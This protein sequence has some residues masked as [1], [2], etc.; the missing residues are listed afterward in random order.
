[1]NLSKKLVLMS[2][3]AILPFQTY[4][5]W[6]P[7]WT[8]NFSLPA[9]TTIKS[10]IQEHKHAFIGLGAV[11]FGVVGY[12]AYKKYHSTENPRHDGDETPNTNHM[13]QIQI[14]PQAPAIQ[15]R[16]EPNLNNQ[17]A[18]EPIEPIINLVD[19]QKPSMPPFVCQPIHII[20]DY[21]TRIKQ[22]VDNVVHN[23]LIFSSGEDSHGNREQI[24]NHHTNGYT[25]I[26]VEPSDN[27]HENK[28]NRDPL[29]NINQRRDKGKERVREIIVAEEENSDEKNHR[30]SY[31][32]Q[33]PTFNDWNETC[34]ALKPYEL[35]TIRGHNEKNCDK[36]VSY[37]ELNKAL[38]A[39][40]ELV[41]NDRC[42]FQNPNHWVNNEMPEKLLQSLTED[43]QAVFDP[44]VQKLVVTKNSIIA[45]HGDVHG[46]VHSLNAY[47][48]DLADKGYL[49]PENPFEIINP[50]FYMI[51]LGD[52]T[53]RGWYGPE[54]IYTVLRL[55]CANP[56]KVFMVRGNHE[57]QSLNAREAIT[58]AD[59]FFAQT[60][61]KFNIK[62]PEINNKSYGDP[63]FNKI[64]KLYETLPLALYL[65]SQGANETT[66]YLLCCHG[67]IEIGFD[68]LPLLNHELGHTIA[69]TKLN[70]LNRLNALTR[71]SEDKELF[72]L[73]KNA[74]NALQDPQ[75]LKNNFNT[76]LAGGC[77]HDHKPSGIITR[78]LS[79]MASLIGFQW[80]DYESDDLK[81]TNENWFVKNTSG[82]GW[83]LSK[84]F[85]KAALITQSDD[86]SV[87]R[88]V[89]RAH[90]HSAQL[91][92]MM[93]LILNKDDRDH[94]ENSGVGKLWPPH[95]KKNA[96]H[97]LGNNCVC[98]FNVCPCTPVGLT[99]G[100][101][102]D[103]YGLLTMAKEFDDWKLHVHRIIIKQAIPQEP[104]I[105]SSDSSQ[106]EQPQNAQS[107]DVTEPQKP[108]SPR[109][110]AFTRHYQSK[111]IKKPSEPIAENNEEYEGFIL[112]I[113]KDTADGVEV[114]GLVNEFT[115]LLISE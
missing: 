3:M 16:P 72:N 113:D 48:L 81:E 46:D 63:I 57:D 17:R 75:D 8:S 77:L 90:Q 59:G 105:T 15:E 99:L 39:Y 18:E 51:F 37:D 60:S 106:N 52:Y 13:P 87:V 96:V 41:A 110:A 84:T 98:T 109:S 5:G 50:N 70:S 27:N 115:D 20:E 76:H 89:F 101:T 62:S 103:T 66:N 55:K 2:L 64:T 91:N 45:F 14:Q 67:G 44:F 85:N 111:P 1:M 71:F 26:F 22:P 88:G 35:P 10:Y 42:I 21:S 40:L 28:E 92:D 47:L 58:G 68:S 23:T 19:H 49:N 53:D 33:F 104:K 43:Q 4:A 93:K 95:D 80:N 7:T 108:S 78:M 83:L 114:E 29:G 73:F 65:G 34:R 56:D 6:M 69:Y 31:N 12:M 79:I 30:A 54:V 102:F 82:R 61:K 32:W 112:M 86:H 24:Q 97:S 36:A 25:Q 94:E 107:G 38:T 9:L 100:Y 11:A 74:N